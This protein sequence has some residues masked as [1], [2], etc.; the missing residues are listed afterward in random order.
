M[1]NAR[2]GTFDSLRPREFL[3]LLSR[4]LRPRATQVVRAVEDAI[5]LVQIYYLWAPSAIRTPRVKFGSVVAGPG[6]GGSA[7]PV[8][9]SS[10]SHCHWPVTNRPMGKIRHDVVFDRPDQSSNGSINDQ[11]Q[12]AVASC[13]DGRNNPLGGE[14]FTNG[15][16]ALIRGSV[17]ILH[18]QSAGVVESL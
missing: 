18:T 6:S 17:C 14:Y 15:W 16:T 2:T 9:P 13:G 12:R 1:P 3:C 5:I 10:V 8:S 4:P 11:F 7:I